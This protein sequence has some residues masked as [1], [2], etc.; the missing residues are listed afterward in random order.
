[1]PALLAWLD[2]SEEHR[3]RMREVIDLFRER[4]T[5]DELG[6]GSVRDAFSDLLFPGLSTIQTRARYFFLIPWVY[7]RLEAERTPSGKAAERARYLQ[8]QLIYALEHGGA[9]A[10]DGI[11][12][13]DSR[14]ALV[15][16]PSAVYWNGLERFGIRRFLGSVG[17]YHR[18][19]DSFY[20][21][22]QNHL[23]GE[24]DEIHERIPTNWHPALPHAPQDLWDSALP[25]LAPR[26]AEFL[27]D[28]IVLTCPSSFLAYMAMQPA[29][30]ITK[31]PFPWDVP[32]LDEIP[33]P[34]SSWLHHARTLSGVMEGAALAYN[35]MLARLAHRKRM[36]GTYK[37]LIEEYEARLEEWGERFAARASV[38][39]DWDLDEFWT[40]VRDAKPNVPQPTQLFISRWIEITQEDPRQTASLPDEVQRL[41]SDRELKLKRRQAR[42]HF[43]RA[44]EMWSGAAGTAPLDYR[45][46]TA[47]RVLSDIYEG[48]NHA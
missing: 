12:G 41:I 43:Q 27:R 5:L 28:Q 6:I 2:Y 18:S 14:E 1:M 19:L 47:R 15:R 11:F 23:R 38:V 30:D 48:L 46:P 17:D 20:E 25:S 34:L 26:E 10:G 44:L 37:D 35:L 3:Q 39:T 21:R 7:L 16:L 36:A 29:S 9:T 32:N 4:D 8:T 22:L 33:D 40:I 45:W 13:W 31:V 42:L 24:G